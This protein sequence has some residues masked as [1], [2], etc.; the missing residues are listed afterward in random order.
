MRRDDVA[1]YENPLFD[2]VFRPGVAVWSALAGVDPDEDDSED[3]WPPLEP[4]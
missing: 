3:D 1:F 4:F 2:K